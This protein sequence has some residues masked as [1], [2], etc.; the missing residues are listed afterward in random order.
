TSFLDSLLPTIP[1]SYI[2]TSTTTTS[3]TL[4][5]HDAL[6]I[7][8]FLKYPH[9]ISCSPLR[10]SS[11]LQ[12]RP[13]VSCADRSFHRPIGPSMICGKNDTNSDTLNGLRSALVFFQYTSIT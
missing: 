5:L 7:S 4:S 1:I 10:T 11:A 6:P 13:A 12:A 9:S 3:Y 2:H 8:I